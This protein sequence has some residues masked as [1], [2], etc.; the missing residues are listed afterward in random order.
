M[1]ANSPA[2]LKAIMKRPSFHL[3]LPLGRLYIQ[4]PGLL[5]R[6]TGPILL[7]NV[8]QILEA[9]ITPNAGVQGLRK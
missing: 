7:A 6:E 2:K 9:Q 8:R 4:V 1:L 5:S 3:C